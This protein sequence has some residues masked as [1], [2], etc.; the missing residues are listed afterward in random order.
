MPH[1]LS[2]YLLA[3]KAITR[4]NAKYGV[5]AKEMYMLDV[6]LTAHYEKRSLRVLDLILMDEIASQ[7]TL[8]AIVKRL[9]KNGLVGLE[10][11]KADLRVK[12]VKPTVLAI[13]KLA[14]CDL[15]LRKIFNI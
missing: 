9:E 5:D 12:L 7:A 13:K 3:A 14:E 2:P 10:S 8:H 11:D 4:I 6:V 1:K 15:A